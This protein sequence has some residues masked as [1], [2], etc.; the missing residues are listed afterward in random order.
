MHFW[1]L[2]PVLIKALGHGSYEIYFSKKWLFVKEGFDLLVRRLAL[3]NLN[4]IN[5]LFRFHNPIFCEKTCIP[6]L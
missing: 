5:P 1:I 3:W 4:L 2:K 6:G